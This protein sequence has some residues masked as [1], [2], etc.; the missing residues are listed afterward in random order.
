MKGRSHL[1]C[2]HGRVHE[3]NEERESH[4]V[5][6]QCT[7]LVVTEVDPER[8]WLWEA[9]EPQHLGN[10]QRPPPVQVPVGA[11]RRVASGQAR[12]RVEREDQVS[13][14]SVDDDIVRAW[15][16]AVRNRSFQNT[17]HRLSQVRPLCFTGGVGKVG[18]ALHS[19]ANVEE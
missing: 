18:V 11:R 14:T 5:P 2:G 8:E 6:D 16:P 17:H 19:R 10:A 13:A 15:V 9:L 4:R 3:P 7:H 1:G 12:A